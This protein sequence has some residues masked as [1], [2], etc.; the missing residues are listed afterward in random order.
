ME[1]GCSAWGKEKKE[2]KFFSHLQIL[3]TLKSDPMLTNGLKIMTNYVFTSECGILIHFSGEI[4]FSQTGFY[5]RENGSFVALVWLF[6]LFFPSSFVTLSIALFFSL[7]TCS[8]R[9]QVNTPPLHTSKFLAR[10]DFSEHKD[11]ALDL[12]G[13][14]FYSMYICVFLIRYF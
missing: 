5:F 6:S 10:R 3:M 2:K 1:G 4:L 11:D 9:R 8:F 12:H 7:L 14:T 13:T